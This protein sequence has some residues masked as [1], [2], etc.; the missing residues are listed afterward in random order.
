MV[1]LASAPTSLFRDKLRSS[2]FALE[3]L[4]LSVLCAMNLCH[5]LKLCE[6]ADARDAFY[7]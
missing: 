4:P 5:L 6:N 2:A 1:Q 3:Q 7:L